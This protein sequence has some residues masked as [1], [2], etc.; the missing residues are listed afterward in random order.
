MSRRSLAEST[1]V[2]FPY[3]ARMSSGVVKYVVDAEYVLRN[4]GERRKQQ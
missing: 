2:Q 4:K 1:L 3:I